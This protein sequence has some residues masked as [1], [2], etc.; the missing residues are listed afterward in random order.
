MNIM[1]LIVNFLL[2]LVFF[3]PV[4]LSY[5]GYRN[6]K[7]QIFIF[8]ISLFSLIS[9]DNIVLCITEI[10]SEFSASYDA[11]FMTVPAF[12]TF[13]YA[14]TFVC[15]IKIIE[16]FLNVKTPLYLYVLLAI[17]L[18]W[19]LFIPMFTNSAIK[20]WCYFLPSQ[21]LRILLCLY[22]LYILKGHAKQYIS[23]QYRIFRNLFIFM[24]I[25]SVLIALED[26]IVIFKVDKYADLSVS[27]TDRNFTESAMLLVCSIVVSK[28]LVNNFQISLRNMAI[29]EQ[30]PNII[31]EP[32]TEKEASTEIQETEPTP[33]FI[34]KTEHTETSTQDYS[35]FFLFCREYQ[36]TT[37]EQDIVKLLLENKDN[38]AISE[39]LVISLGTVKAHVHNVFSKTE[40]KRRQ[41][42]IELYEDFQA[43]ETL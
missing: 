39:E 22:V 15:V 37:R 8:I 43:E 36:L 32:E 30:N 13:I 4:T 9:I 28:M 27:I 6:T 34:R 17:V 1:I 12:K 24:G 31:P 42:L 40:V 16:L 29:P 25:V 11:M 18:S 7:K 33:A 41:Q 38:N 2:L 10:S 5:I 20:V 21:I 23:K 14:G 19:L 3:T 35:K 26:T